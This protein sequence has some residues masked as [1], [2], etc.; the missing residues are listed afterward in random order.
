MDS[1]RYRYIWFNAFLFGLVDL[2]Q[3]IWFGRFILKEL[4]V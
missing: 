3:K 2:D 4:V 1:V